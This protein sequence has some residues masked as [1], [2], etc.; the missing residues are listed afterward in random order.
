M[1]GVWLIDRLFSN[2]AGRQ[3][4]LF[5]GCGTCRGPVE[6]NLQAAILAAL[7]VRNGKAVV[8]VARRRSG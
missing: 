1:P 7:R 5:G 8:R 4:L 3:S 2:V 6:N